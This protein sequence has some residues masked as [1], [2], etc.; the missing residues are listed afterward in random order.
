MT[1]RAFLI[2]LVFVA[3]ISLVDPL[4][5]FISQYGSWFTY[6]SFPLGAVFVL[7]L[8][9]VFV[10]V[11][12]KLFR[13]GW[14]FSQAELMLVWC[15]IF[16]SAAVPCEGLGR[17]WYQLIAGPAYLS[18]RPE[19]HWEQ[20]GSLTHAPEGLVLSK[21]PYSEAARQ[22]YE[23]TDRGRVPWALWMRPLMH[24]VL[25]LV[26]MYAAIFCLCVILRRQWVESER[27]MFPLARVPLEFTEG[28][29]GGWLPDIFHNK[30]FLLGL[31]VALAWRFIRALP[32]LAGAASG[33]NIRF[34]FADVFQGT[35]LQAAGFNNTGLSV[36][37]VGFAFLVPADVSLSVWFFY[38]FGRAEIGLA[39]GLALPVMQS[40]RAT[41]FRWQ[42]LGSYLAF[43]GGMLF[44]ARRHL[45][46]V[47]RKALGRGG[48]DD[49]DEPLSYPVAFW[50]FWAA[51]GACL[52]WYIW[53]GMRPLTAVGVLFLTFCWFLV[54]ARIVSQGG[55]YVATNMWALTD[56]MH[57]GTGGY[58]FGA[59]GAVIASFQQGLLFGGRTTLVAPQT[60]NA[61][62][63]AEVFKKRRRLLVP[64]LMISLLV[65]IAGTSYTVLTQ[66]YSQGAL[67]FW[68]ANLQVNIA[69]GNMQRAHSIITQPSQSVNPFF[70]S[71]TFGAVAMA[72]V[73]VMRARFYWWPVHGIGLLVAAS[74]HTSHLWIQFF[75]GWLIKMG[76]MRL[77]GGRALRQGRYFFIAVIVVEFFISSVSG[78]LR[79]ASGGAIPGF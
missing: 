22:Y 9:T 34:P 40:G 57:S 32:V 29:A 5:S 13:R 41:F 73:M 8:L 69:M 12:L 60:M 77:A 76:V 72:F 4:T 42:Q 11:G 61:F 74:G 62:R 49:S 17:Y 28:S 46:A 38:L 75:I 37:G 55:L 2:G 79:I 47:A 30:G 27:L 70:G 45:L 58:A 7:V 48:V 52:T 53:H 1:L 16:V 33:W 67:N 56:I 19:M 23:G 59:T 31:T 25:L 71:L 36:S 3:V 51:I 26:P 50:G 63:I 78:I 15:M 54:Y 68:D 21:D 10:N 6:S 24:W 43:V 35:P 20:N 44:M 65:A 66:A 39:K 64:V 14:E 18:R